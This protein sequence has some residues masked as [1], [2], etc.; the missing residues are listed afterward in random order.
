MAKLRPMQQLT[1]A[2]LTGTYCGVT[3][4]TKQSVPMKKV[5]NRGCMLSIPPKDVP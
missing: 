1:F 4:A 2:L 3:F 5:K